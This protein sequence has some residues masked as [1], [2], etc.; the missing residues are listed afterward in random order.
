M[1]W[2]R[3]TWATPAKGPGDPGR[4]ATHW[5]NSD[6]NTLYLYWLVVDKTP[7]KN[8]SSSIG[9]I[10]PSIWKNKNVPNQQPVYYVSSNQGETH[11]YVMS[12][13]AMTCSVA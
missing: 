1:F 9:M 4:D 7:L 8:M 6:H 3:A 10:I 2:M 13:N 5:S 12:C 11:M